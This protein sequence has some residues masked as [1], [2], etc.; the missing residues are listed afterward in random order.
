LRAGGLGALQE[1][2]AAGANR[3]AAQS[4]GAR[5]DVCKDQVA[6]VFKVPAEFGASA[7]CA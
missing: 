1:Y 6:G 7:Q 5:I 4:G 3:T 2:L